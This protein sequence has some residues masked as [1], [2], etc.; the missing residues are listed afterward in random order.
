[1]E[2]SLQFGRHRNSW[3]QFN[4]T[5]YRGPRP[6]NRVNLTSPSSGRRQMSLTLLKSGGH[7]RY[8]LVTAFFTSTKPI[9]S[10]VD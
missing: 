2:I 5:R 9:R 10:L 7:L 3:N 6:K 8:E 4:R 1:M